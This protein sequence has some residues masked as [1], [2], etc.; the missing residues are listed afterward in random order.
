[1]T[2]A[3][4]AIGGAS[5]VGGLVSSSAS[6]KLQK[7]QLA[8]QRDQFNFAKDR[9]NNYQSKYGDIEQAQIDSAKKGVIADLQGVTNRA[10]TDVATQYANAQAQQARQMQR[11][12]INPNSGRAQALSSQTALDQA[13]TA[14]ANVTTG[15]ENERRYADT[16]TRAL[17]QQALNTGLSQM[18]MA[19][20]N[21][22]SASNAM[23]N[24]YGQMAA[25]ESAQAGQFFNTA[26]AIGGKYLGGLSSS[27]A[28]TAAPVTSGVPL[29]TA[30]LTNPSAAQQGITLAKNTNGLINGLTTGLN[31]LNY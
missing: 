19:A 16:Q 1:M 9:Y 15:R 21:M 8:L 27:P 30:G 5:I 11:M 23:A 12:G 7:E 17:R 4:V 22:N 10:N 28:T 18:N 3:A 26:G 25:N 20:N 29:A 13:K 31:G 14:A 2:Y 6:R 24:T